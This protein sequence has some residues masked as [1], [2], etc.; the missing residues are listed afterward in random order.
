MTEPVSFTSTTP[1]HLLPFLFAGQAQ[2]EFFVNE[3]LARIDLLLHPA[4]EGERADPPADPVAG[5]CWIIG[6]SATGAWQGHD[7]QLAAWQGG[8]WLVAAA[9]PGMRV[10][11]RTSGG[12]LRYEGQWERI[13]RPAD[14][15]GGA[16]VDAEARA[17]I[18]AII[19]AMARF[20]TFS[21]P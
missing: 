9:V 1:R 5:E 16:T 18:A 8:Q 4:V 21:A 7:G 15:A 10:H 19:E 2:R 20:G 11:D 3:S 12:Q 6:P 14:P 17:A 13:A